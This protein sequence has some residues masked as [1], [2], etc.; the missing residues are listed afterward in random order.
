[1]VFGLWM[2][3][4]KFVLRWMMNGEGTVEEAGVPDFGV[5]ELRERG[6]KFWFQ[7][8]ATGE[9]RSIFGCGGFDPCFCGGL[10]NRREWV[11]G[12]G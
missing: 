2:W 4:V 12:F 11:G 10:E 6:G 5:E 7:D 9:L 1:M 3:E 8:G